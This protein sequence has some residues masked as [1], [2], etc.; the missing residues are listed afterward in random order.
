[1]LIFFTFFFYFF[2][3]CHPVRQRADQSGIQQYSKKWIPD[4]PRQGEVRG[5]TNFKNYFTD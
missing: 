5:M 1:L 2:P 3:I 4:T